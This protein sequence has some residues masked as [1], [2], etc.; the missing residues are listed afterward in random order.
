MSTVSM[1]K[2]SWGSYPSIFNLGHRA[3]KDLLTV[4]VN[5][6][7]KVDGSQFS[8][9]AFPVASPDGAQAGFGDL[10]L[11]VRSKG[12]PIYTMSPPG[13][14]RGAT[15]TALRLFKEG[16]LVPG[17]TYRGEALQAPKHNSLQYTRTPKDHV[18]IFDVETGDQTFLNYDAKKLH[19]EQHLGL[20]VV[21][22]LFDGFITDEALFRSF[23]ARES[24][25]GGQLIE[26]IVLKPCNYDLFGVDKKVLFGKYVSESF[27]EVHKRAWAESNPTRTDVVEKLIE[28]LSS[29]ARYQKAVIH[30]REREAIT[31]SV[32]DIGAILAEVKKDIAKEEKD[33]IAQT[34]YRHFA[35]T[36]IRRAAANVPQWWK[37]ELVKAQFEGSA[38]QAMEAAVADEY[39]ADAPSMSG[40]GLGLV[41]DEHRG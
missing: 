31:D 27:R 18:I 16:R 10:E 13:L 2:G 26:G 7:E 38:E 23:L 39:A 20:E 11:R 15:A 17:W 37:D 19:V 5:V 8:F 24:V 40:Y 12:A 33:F 1:S 29:P 3:V 25:L 34:L 14:F 4:P 30:L 36:I 22:R 6:E 35:D 28:A 41:E 21:P 32:K 9:G